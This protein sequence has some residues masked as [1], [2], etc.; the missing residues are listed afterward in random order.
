MKRKLICALLTLIMITALLPVS[1]FAAQEMEISDSGVNFIKRYEGYAKDQYYDN[2]GWYIGYGTKCED[3]E[4]PDGL[5]EVEATELLKRVLKENYVVQVNNYLKRHNLSVS[6][7]QFDAL[8]SFTYN[9]GGGWMNSGYRFSSYLIRGIDNY[10]DAQ[11]V[12]AMGVWSHVGS[13]VIP[14]LIYRRIAEAKLFLYGD[15]TG[16]G[17]PKEFAYLI[18]NTNGGVV[19]NDVVI[20]EKGKVYG[21]LPS[22]ARAGYTLDGWYTA[23][24]IRISENNIVT[25]NLNVS[26]RWTSNIKQYTDVSSNNWYYAYVTD[27]TV[28]EVINGYE[29]GTFRPNN[30][31]SWGEALKL[32]M[33]ATGKGNQSATGRH[34]ASG[35]LDKAVSTGLVQAGKV[36]DLDAPITRFEIAELAVKAMGLT[37]QTIPSPFYDTVDTY[38]LALYKN[39]IVTGSMVNGRLVYQ[40]ENNINRAEMSAIIWRIY[41][42]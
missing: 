4:Y 11:V 13:G 3:G 5:T 27:L 39:D 17:S 21:T 36:S 23:E 31:V 14:G 30:T 25:S 29:D 10:T 6:Q 40:G 37:P 35:F 8:V 34:W 15:Y 1:V 16:N 28:G 22:A 38:V 24:G 32:I 9:L 2:G 20:Y 12:D 42:Y 7:P 19:D 26:A 18:L 33:L 41:N